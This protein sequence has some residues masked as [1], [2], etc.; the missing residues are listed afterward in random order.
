MLDLGRLRV[1]RE[2]KLR[3]TVG[4]VADALGYSPSAVSQQ[5]AQLQKD[6]KVPLLE[7]VGRRLR[8][9]EA[10]EVLADQA[11]ILLAQAQ[12]AEEST[13]A[14]GGRV[15]GVARVLGHQVALLN[16]VAPTLPALRQRYPELVVEVI[17]EESEDVLRKLALQEVD[18]VL[19]NEYVHMPMPRSAE[20]ENE[21]L[22]IEPMRL[23]LPEGHRLAKAA[24]VRLAELSGDPWMSTHLGTRHAEMMRRACAEIG[25]FRPMVRHYTNDVSVA[26]S[27]IAAGAAVGL[28][29]ELALGVS[30]PG[31]AVRSLTDVDLRRRIVAW[32]RRGAA[33]RP[34]V[35]AVLG[36]LRA[37]ADA[38]VARR[39]GVSRGEPTSSTGNGTGED[40]GEGS[41]GMKR[42]R[43]T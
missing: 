24:S 26:L 5:L 3:G 19:Y 2:L 10:G 31:V 29:P 7:R 9:T 32:R 13:L 36:E 38:I 30:R 28:L 39:S 23:V 18:L 40:A 27:L 22:L 8:L 33:S 25:G 15:A 12:H 17:D 4:A 14:A 16:L 42:M 6:V 21:T 37:A 20:L 35:D 34:S 11:E 43:Q 1:L 41:P